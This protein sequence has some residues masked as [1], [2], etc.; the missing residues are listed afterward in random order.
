MSRSVG[1]SESGSFWQIGQWGNS[2]YVEA[3]YRLVRLMSLKGIMQV[4]CRIPLVRLVDALVLLAA[5]AGSSTAQLS[6]MTVDKVSP[7]SWQ[8]GISSDVLLSLSG[9]RLD[10]VVGV[11]VKH[12]GVRVI[13]VE[14]PDANHLLVVLR[15]SSDAEPGTMMLQLW[16]RF[17]T[18]FATVALLE[19]NAAQ[20]SG[21]E[22]AD[23]K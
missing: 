21:A 13:H 7:S 22:T 5:L 2:E 17:T 1:A 3:S 4:F 14:S 9:E 12:K 20:V 16:T 11:K 8:T 6:P 19:K 10:G 18:T 23:E 15:I